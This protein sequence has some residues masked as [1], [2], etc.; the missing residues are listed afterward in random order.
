MN[1]CTSV[2]ASVYYNTNVNV[3]VTSKT[4]ALQIYNFLETSSFYEVQTLVAD[5]YLRGITIVLFDALMLFSSHVHIEFSSFRKEQ[6]E[7]A[8]STVLFIRM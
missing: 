6:F 2:Y 3:Y 1:V 4:E 7:N 8:I 5:R